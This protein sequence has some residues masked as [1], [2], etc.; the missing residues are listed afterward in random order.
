MRAS[1]PSMTAKMAARAAKA[2]QTGKNLA[3]GCRRRR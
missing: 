2:A 1:G 3:V